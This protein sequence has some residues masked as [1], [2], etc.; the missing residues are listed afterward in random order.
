MIE[1]RRKGGGGEVERGGSKEGGR[2]EEAKRKGDEGEDRKKEEGRGRRRGKRMKG[3]DRKVP[4]GGS[5]ILLNA[6]LDLNINTKY[7]KI[8]Y[9]A[10]PNF[11]L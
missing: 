1:R 5:S 7:R 10:K 9:S 11:S 8:N 3:E 4:V 2:E 6:N